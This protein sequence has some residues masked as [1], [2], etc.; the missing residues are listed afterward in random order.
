MLQ[1][2]NQGR[3][4]HGVNKKGSKTATSVIILLLSLWR[5]NVNISLAF[6]TC[7]M[8]ELQEFKMTIENPAWLVWHQ[9]KEIVMHWKT[10]ILFSI[11][12]D[13]LL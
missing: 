5:D 2:K 11:K 6:L 7:P 3:T 12:F 1:N 9:A 4:A 8:Y 13:P 10:L